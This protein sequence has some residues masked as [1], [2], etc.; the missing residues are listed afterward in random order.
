LVVV[1]PIALEPEEQQDQ[2]ED[3]DDGGDKDAS[4]DA[5]LTPQQL[6]QRVFEVTTERLAFARSKLTT[7]TVPPP[8]VNA[9]ATG[10][11]VPDEAP[12]A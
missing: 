9:A 2:N 5:T 1:G 7:A 8:T 3:S 12:E 10:P 4:G 6:A 11:L